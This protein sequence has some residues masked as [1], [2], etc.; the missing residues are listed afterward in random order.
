MEKT[1]Y[2]DLMTLI[3]SLEQQSA[4]L[5]ADLPEGVPPGIFEKCRGFVRIR[6]GA[7]AGC[8]IIGKSGPLLDGQGALQYLVDIKK[9]EVKLVGVKPNTTTSSPS[10]TPPAQTQPGQRMPSSSLSSTLNQGPASTPP[11]QNPYSTTAHSQGTHSIPP[12]QSLA[13]NQYASNPN[14]NHYIPQNA[15]QTP[16]TSESLAHLPYPTTSQPYRAQNSAQLPPSPYT[17]AYIEQYREGRSTVF[18]PHQRMALH[19]SLLENVPP[20]ERIVIRMVLA[21][22]NGQRT[23]DQIKEQLRLPADTVDRTLIELRR[24]RVID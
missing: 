18:I 17:S 19:P 2:L 15:Y 14:Q 7:I 13:Q 6:N 16:Q 4:T 22:V 9:W 10:V 1:Y 8:S 20:R 23:V 21:M 24:M 12:S 11:P 5:H 3:E